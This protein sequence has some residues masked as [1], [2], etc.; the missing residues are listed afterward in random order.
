MIRRS[1]V[2]L[3]T[4]LAPPPLAAQHGAT[5]A[6]HVAPAEARQFDFLVG[7]WEL[8][9]EPKATTLA[10]RLHGAPQMVGTWKAWRGFDGWGIEDE[11]RIMDRSGNPMALVHTLR[12]YD[13]AGR[14]WLV[15]GLDAYR[16]RISSS[17]AEWSGREMVVR[18]EQTDANGKAYQTRSRFTDIKPDRFTMHQDRSDDGGKTWDENVVTVEAKRVA[19]A[20]PR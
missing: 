16:G 19:A 20:A 11:L 12:G 14:R 5:I 13:A 18:G 1:A 6:S 9:V 2:L 8:T 4:L 17:T 7:Q 3:L 15:S 10:A